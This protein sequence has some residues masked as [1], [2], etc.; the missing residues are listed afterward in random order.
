MDLDIRQYHLSSQK[1]DKNQFDA[2]SDSSSAYYK[3]RK[4]NH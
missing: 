2:L 3:Q 4:Y 1:I